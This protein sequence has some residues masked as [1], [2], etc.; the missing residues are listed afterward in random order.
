MPNQSQTKLMPGG[1][2]RK[3]KPNKTE[4]SL[5]VRERWRDFSYHYFLLDTVI[6]SAY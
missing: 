1:L 4:I 6:V 3:A 5:V 2:S